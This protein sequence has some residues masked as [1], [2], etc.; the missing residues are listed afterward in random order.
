MGRAGVK[1]VHLLYKCLLAR[2]HCPLT[3]ANVQPLMNLHNA[4]MAVLTILSAKLQLA[5]EQ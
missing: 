1:G 4:T 2:T 5:I 3:K